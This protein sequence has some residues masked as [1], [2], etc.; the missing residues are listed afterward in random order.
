MASLISPAQQE[1][2][3][4]SWIRDGAR[5]IPFRSP[6][7]AL[8]ASARRGRLALRR[9]NGCAQDEANP[10]GMTPMGMK[11]FERTSIGIRLLGKRELRGDSREPS[12]AQAKGQ[13]P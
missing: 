10:F 5:E 7:T 8:G 6:S 3:W 11:P 9:K 2:G 1:C 12:C 13:R 4:C